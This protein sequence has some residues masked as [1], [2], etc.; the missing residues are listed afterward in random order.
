[1]KITGYE[2]EI[3]ILQELGNRIK[4]HRIALNITQIEL[5]QKC[6]ISISTETRIE[7]GD[8][9]KMSN[10][11]KIMTALGIIDNINIL[12]PEEQPD[13]KAIFEERPSRK[14]ASGNRKKQK[15]VWIWEDDK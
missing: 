10:Y 14:R 7:N 9:S 11:I 5:A 13:Y 6:G 3:L 1:M 8:D 4:Q 2:S 15:S 12:I